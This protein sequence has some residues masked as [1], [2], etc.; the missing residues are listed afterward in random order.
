LVLILFVTVH[1]FFYH[2]LSII[3]LL[4]RASWLNEVSDTNHYS[5]AFSLDEST[6]SFLDDTALN[7]Q[8]FVQAVILSARPV[9]SVART[10]TSS[11]SVPAEEDAPPA[12]VTS[13]GVI[14]GDESPPRGRRLSGELTLGV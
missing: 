1:L 7:E 9:T 6:S 10:M 14:A 13:P 2:K 5:S 3:N 8:D 12:T 11:S 4:A